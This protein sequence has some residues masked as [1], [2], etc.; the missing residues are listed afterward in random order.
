MDDGQ[1]ILHNI[2][3]NNGIYSKNTF[4]LYIFGVIAPIIVENIHKDGIIEIQRAGTCI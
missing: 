1:S 3:E 2:F 4:E